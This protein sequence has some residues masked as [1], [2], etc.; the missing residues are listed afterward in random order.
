MSLFTARRASAARIFAQVP[1]SPRSWDG[2]GG[3]SGTGEQ[4]KKKEDGEKGELKKPQLGEET[5]TGPKGVK[6]SAE[7]VTTLVVAVA[8]VESADTSGTKKKIKVANHETES[9]PK[10]GTDAASATSTNSRRAS[11]HRL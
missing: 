11:L 5:V 3:E 9:V 7:S 1:P 2:K 6:T 4:G 10:V 8:E